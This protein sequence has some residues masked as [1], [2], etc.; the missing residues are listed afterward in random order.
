MAASQADCKQFWKTLKRHLYNYNGKPSITPDV[1][2]NFFNDLLTTG[3]V[4][5]NS[6]FDRKKL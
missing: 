4:E 2:L 6:S 5:N 3:N 1:W